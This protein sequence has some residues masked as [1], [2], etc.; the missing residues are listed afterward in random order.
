VVVAGPLPDLTGIEV[1]VAVGQLSRIDPDVPASK[2]VRS[3]YPIRVAGEAEVAPA[4]T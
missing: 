3:V 2:V 4:G 1:W